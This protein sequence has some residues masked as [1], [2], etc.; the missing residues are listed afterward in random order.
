MTLRIALPDWLESLNRES[1]SFSQDEAAM[2]FVI[3]L[4]ARNI[5]E[6]GG[7][8]A[9]AVLDEHGGLIAAGVN[10]VIPAKCSVLHA[11]IVALMLA[12]QKRA[13]YSLSSIGARLYS[14]CEPCAMC[15][16]AIPWSGISALF[17]A[18]SAA[19][20]ESIGFDEG[21]KPADW[22]QALRRRGIAVTQ[23]LLRAE[24]HRVLD[25]YLQAGHALY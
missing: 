16:G 17:C 25:D 6:G 3:E 20:A 22:P 5:R 12:Q 19:D 24:A 4:S 7:P 2:R 21:D 14:S 9:A 1:L 10:R 11:E 18:A 13:S 8:F 15:L 23:N